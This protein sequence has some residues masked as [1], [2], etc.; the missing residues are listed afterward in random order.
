ME[1]LGVEL[2]LINR[3]LGDPYQARLQANEVVDSV[4]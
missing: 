3:V 2:K 4:A 1:V